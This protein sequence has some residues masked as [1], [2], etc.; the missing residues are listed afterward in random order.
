MGGCVGDELRVWHSIAYGVSLE[1]R[2]SKVDVNCPIIGLFKSQ[3]W[4]L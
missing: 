3:F 1:W 4:L 2:L